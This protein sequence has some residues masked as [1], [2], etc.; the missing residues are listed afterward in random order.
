MNRYLL[1]FHIILFLF[2]ISYSLF[3]QDA[4]LKIYQEKTDN[5]YI[6]YA[7]NIDMAPYAIRLS[8][9]SLENLKPDKNLNSYI[10][11]VPAKS[12][13][14]EI[15]RL[16]KL[17][18]GNT[19]FKFNYIFTIGN[20]NLKPDEDFAYWFPYSHGHKERVGQGNNGPGTHIGI[21]AIDF[22]LDI[23]SPVHAA[24]SGVVIEVK[25]DS[26]T[27]GNDPNFEKYGNYI[28]VYHEDGTIAD[29]VHLQQ[30]G[31]LVTKGER[32]KTGEKIGLSGN[33]GYS[34]G[35]HLHF[36][37]TF[38]R[39]FQSI[40]LPVKF[41]NYNGEKVVPVEGKSYYAYHTGKPEFQA[42]TKEDFNETL[43]ENKVEKSL[44]KNN[45]EITTSSY[46]DYTLIYVDNGF[47]RNI[48]GKLLV[49][50][51]NMESSKELPYQFEVPAKT[52]LYLLALNPKDALKK[53]GYK[54]SAE[55]K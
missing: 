48:S 27:G 54:L 4:P 23:G 31:S 24:R 29:Y 36:M 10:A 3:A 38:S 22:N 18:K 16:I 15:L 47:N 8:F 33:T 34:S 46:D 7:D 42:E 52:K 9:S 12:S 51:E 28:R 45:I 43:Y 25:E 13:K 5:G 44:K 6:F 41:L 53:F 55:F 1:Q 40:S 30:N 11:L 14:I 2:F 20:P 26:N 39:N 17:K 21:N 19:T 37:V 49:K 35:P 50:V 32:V